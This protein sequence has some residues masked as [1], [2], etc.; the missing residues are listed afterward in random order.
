MKISV[1]LPVLAPTPFLRAMTEFCIKTLRAHA[2]QPFEL[3]VVEAVHSSFDPHNLRQLNSLLSDRHTFEEDS[4]WKDPFLIVDKYLNFPQKIGNIKEFN[5]G[6][7]VATGEFI[8]STGNDVIVPPH[9]DTELLR[10]F[11]KNPDC[12]VASLSALEPGAVIGPLTQQECISQQPEIGTVEFV[13]GMYSP[14]MMWRKGWRMDES[15]VKIYC[16][17][18]LIMRVYAKGLRVYRSCRA[19]VRHLVRMTSDS[20]NP[21]QHQRDLARDEKL[22]YQR[23]GQSRLL[24]FGLIRSGQ[25]TYGREHCAFTVPINLHYTGETICPR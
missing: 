15:Y 4:K 16:D 19:H 8:V 18:D 11:E 25:V 2:D 3:V 9:W 14:F 12:G 5:Q 24:I 20:V 7:D 10:V 13:E 21:E 17:S 1:I 22:F 23:W 6:L